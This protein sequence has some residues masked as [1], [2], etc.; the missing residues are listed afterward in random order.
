MFFKKMSYNYE[1]HTCDKHM[2]SFKNVYESE[3]E[4]FLI[5]SFLFIPIMSL[6]LPIRYPQ[7]IGSV[8]SYKLFKLYRYSIYCK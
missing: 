8:A 2:G 3:F 1:I 4:Y 7:T 6:K 5:N